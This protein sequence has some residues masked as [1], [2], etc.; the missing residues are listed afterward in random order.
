VRRALGVLAA[1]SALLAGCGGNEK[2]SLHSVPMAD[3]VRVQAQHYECPVA[4]EVCFRNAILVPS[5]RHATNAD[6]LVQ[7]ELQALLSHRWQRAAGVTSH[8]FAATS[9][10]GR[11]F[12]TLSSG[13]GELA[14]EQAGQVT[15]DETLGSQ[16]E[17]LTTGRKPAVALTVQAGPDAGP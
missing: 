1:V 7:L 17:R 9:P 4:K 15:W 11:L 8:Q 2:L 13:A 10:D 12:V 3:S 14:D 5:G 6:T 16:L